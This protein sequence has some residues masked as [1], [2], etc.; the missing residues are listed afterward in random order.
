[1]PK[2]KK[3]QTEN[4]RDE[5]NLKAANTPVNGSHPQAD[6]DLPAENQDEILEGEV[7]QASEAA[8]EDGSISI[9]EKLALTQAALEASEA[10]ASEYLDGWQRAQAEF[11]NFRKR[12]ERERELMRFEA[13]G[14]VARR[15]LPIVD[16]MQRALK[17][18]PKEGEGAAWAEGIELIYRKLMSILEAE[19]VTPIE[20]AGQIFDPNL[21]EAVVQSESDEHESGV[22]IEVLQTGY[23]MGERVLRPAMV[24][25]A[26]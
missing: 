17:D 21:H 14:R 10:K 1:M 7:I 20:A 12:Q 24:R 19:G 13:V 26:A 11:T 16:D 5:D 9:E 6:S 4:I 8:L 3:D 23:K 15:Y 18:R 22:V 25:V 2:K